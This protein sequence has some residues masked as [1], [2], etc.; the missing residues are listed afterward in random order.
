[1]IFNK[2]HISSKLFLLILLAG[3]MFCCE[4]E[5]NLVF[6]EINILE[7]KEA[8]VEINIPQAESQDIVSSRINSELMEFTNNAL[9]IDSVQGQ[10]DSF[11]KGIEQFN[12]SYER[13][14]NS[15]NE[16]LQ[17]EIT[18]WEAAID[19]EVTYQS[20]NL[21]C[22]AMTTYLNTGAIHGSSK[23]TFLNFDASTGELLD[24]NAFVN[25]KA[26]LLKMIKPY[27]EKEVGE[28]S[29]ENLKL[30]ETIGLDDEG[31]IILYNTNEIPSYTDGLTEFK[32]PFNEIKSLLKVY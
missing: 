20:H 5:I 13:F 11:E 22:I 7:E 3:L 19:G 24:Y 17:L 18:P 26:E 8:V 25:D 23:V 32:I 2:T 30:P 1:M 27:F 16:E 28:I 9:N 29:D 15:L 6:S 14:S 10:L 31:I 12:L 21:I 4:E